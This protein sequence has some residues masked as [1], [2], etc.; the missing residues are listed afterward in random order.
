[1][2]VGEIPMSLSMEAAKWRSGPDQECH[3]CPKQ[4]SVGAKRQMSISVSR[5]Q[6]TEFCYFELESPEIVRM[7]KKT[8][9]FIYI[10]IE[11]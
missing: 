2:F 3:G 4:V 9:I 1:M 7:E 8:N 5:F 11:S 10:E 6:P